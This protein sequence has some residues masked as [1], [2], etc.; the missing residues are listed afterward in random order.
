MTTFSRKQPKSLLNPASGYLTGYSHTLNPYA[1]CQYGCSYC[2]VRKMP[3]AL[4]RREPWG[5]WVDAKIGSAQLL[6]KELAKEKRKGPVTIFMSSS[7]DPYQPLEASEQI[8]R[9]FL[10]AMVSDPPDFLFV[11]TR[12]PLVT[13]DIDLLLA[14]KDRLRISMTVE[15]DLESVRKAFTPSAPPVAGR[16]AALRKLAEAG[17]PTQAAVSPVL[18]SS[19]AF[20][21]IVAG[22]TDRVCI[23][24]FF[25]GDGSLGR[26]TE[27]L[28]IRAIFEE[29]GFGDWYDR[30]RY[31]DIVS[32]FEAYL[33]PK[34]IKISQAGFLPDV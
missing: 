10:E 13:R 22:V 27:T 3:V 4:F 21:E 31:L 29:M 23:D 1:G 26:R 7:T 17:L 24:D 11:Q 12:S 19:P 14:L 32:A 34:R 6:A 33:P 2:Y 20:A 15:T 28:G 9:S 25:M 16:L 8:T 5:E 30:K 18:P